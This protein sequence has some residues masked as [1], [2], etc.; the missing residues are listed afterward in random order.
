MKQLI[1]DNCLTIRELKDWLSEIPDKHPDTGEERTVWMTTGWCLSSPVHKV[2]PLN[3][4]GRSC[5]ILFGTAQYD[6]E[7]KEENIEKN[8]SQ[9]LKSIVGSFPDL[10]D[11]SDDY[12]LRV[13]RV[14]AV[15]NQFSGLDSVIRDCAKS[16]DPIYRLAAALWEAIA[17]TVA[18]NGGGK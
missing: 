6:L 4:D 9:T 13:R 12:T 5:D 10:P 2:E 8:T 11:L 17:G 1:V 3:C 18:N 7:N 14:D 16:D 15:Q